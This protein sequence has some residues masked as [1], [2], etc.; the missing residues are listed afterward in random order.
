MAPIW[1][2]GWEQCYYTAIDR[3]S[4][5][6]LDATIDVRY[7][8]EVERWNGWWQP[9]A[10]RTVEIWRQLPASATG[11]DEVGVT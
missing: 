11:D 10:A 1:S 7:E 6:S 2:E 5:H 3:L 8:P 4:E 9:A